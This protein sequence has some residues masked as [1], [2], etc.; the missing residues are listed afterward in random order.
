[1]QLFVTGERL[2]RGKGVELLGF[3]FFLHDSTMH[4]N[5]FK[6]KLNSCLASPLTVTAKAL[7]LE[8]LCAVSIESHRVQK[9]CPELLQRYNSSALD[10]QC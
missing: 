9:R 7:F 2:Y 5:M 4:L 6:N 10:N 3:F 1:M 8:T